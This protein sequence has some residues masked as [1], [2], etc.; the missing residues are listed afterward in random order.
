MFS[1]PDRLTGTVGLRSASERWNWSPGG[2]ATGEVSHHQCLYARA[3]H[4]YVPSA[5][6]EPW[7]RSRIH[8]GEGHRASFARTG[9]TASI[10]VVALPLAAGRGMNLRNRS[11]CTCIHTFLQYLCAAVGPPSSR[12]PLE[13][14]MENAISLENTSWA[15]FLFNYQKVRN[16][17]LPSDARV[18][19]RAAAAA[20]P[21]PRPPA[22]PAPHEG[23]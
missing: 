2:G 12:P 15:V 22:G 9:S 21:A 17:A 14:V 23:I 6:T 5:V 3:L 10:A 16:S 4:M 18:R 1:C 20:P 8:G 11:V 13:V 19:P 7:T